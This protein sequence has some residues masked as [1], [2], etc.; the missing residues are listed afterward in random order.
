M[1]LQVFFGD[2]EHT[3]KDGTYSRILRA[4][5]WLYLSAAAATFLTLGLY[6]SGAA[7]GILKVVSLPQWLLAQATA[8]GLVYLLIQY[9]L[10]LYQLAVTYDLVLSERLAFRRADELSAATDRLKRTRDELAAAEAAEGAAASNEFE[11][12]KSELE[13]ARTMEAREA[14][15][16]GA[17]DLGFLD[18]ETL[19]DAQRR[20]LAIMSKLRADAERKLQGASL[21]LTGAVSNP[22]LQALR[23]AA[24]E[25]EAALEYLRRQNPA[26]RR[27][28]SAA[29]KIIDVSRV[30]P[31][32]IVAILAA[33]ALLHAML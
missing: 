12:A 20:R 11:A 31:P 24:T 5:K 13:A 1:A 23:Q 7:N 4:R 22:E 26:D 18:P 21:R 6:D 33:G 30:V 16:L 19:E 3:A 29:E 2:D 28:Y 14:E 9:S 32:L 15:N 25:A 27:G 10:L 17:S 8:A